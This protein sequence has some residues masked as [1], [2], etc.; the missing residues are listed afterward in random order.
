MFGMQSKQFL[1][2][3]SQRISSQSRR[4]MF[5]LE[6]SVMWWKTLNCFSVPFRCF[7][8]Q[9]EETAII[10]SS[11]NSIWHSEFVRI[12]APLLVMLID[13]SLILLNFRFFFHVLR[14]KH[15]HQLVS[16][17]R[18][19]NV[20]ARHQRQ[21][22]ST[23][24][25]LRLNLEQGKDKDKSWRRGGDVGI[26]LRLMRFPFFQIQFS[27]LTSGARRNVSDFF[28]V[29]LNC[30]RFIIRCGVYNVR[31]GVMEN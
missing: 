8:Q 15:F 7:D 17:V 6:E 25:T 22:L 13:F 10:S 14:H 2:T 11:S 26:L 5:S 24:E 21:Q 20:E 12:H 31:W 4:E 3:Q 30:D 29:P 9:I 18:C 27:I 19:S 16:S 23:L 1:T 28:C